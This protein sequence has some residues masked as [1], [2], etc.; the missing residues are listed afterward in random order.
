MTKM[1]QWTVLTAVAVLI[2][3]AG[4]WLLLVK[5]QHSQVSSLKVQAAGQLQS[6][7]LL[8]Q[9]IAARQAQQKQ[10]PHEQAQLQKLSTQVPTIPDEP[11]I[12][13]S[14]SS[15]A[16]GA[17][18][19]LLSLT[20]GAVVSVTA[21]TST[22]GAATTLPSASSG[23]LVVLPFTM[24]VIGSYSNLESYFQLLEKL[25]RAL[26][27]TGWSMCPEVPGA[28]AAT[29]CSAPTVP[30]GVSIPEGTLGSTISGEVFFSPT[31]STVAAG[32]VATLPGTTAPT[33][34]TTTTT[35][36]TTPASPAATAT[37]APTA[38][39]PGN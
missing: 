34:S 3:F 36:A 7:Q 31:T 22:G 12:I 20:P 5:P 9:Q 32:G 29:A 24:A 11:G 25:P 18:V 37:P 2:I 38:T 23:Q 30:Q 17:G 14:L 13:R 8:L 27:V 33:T 6:N 1:R 39:A 10:L 35:P 15:S 21:T 26:L 4:G 19:N 28:G 16:D